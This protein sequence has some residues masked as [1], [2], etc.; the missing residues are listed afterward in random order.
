MVLRPEEVIMVASPLMAIMVL[1]VSLLLRPLAVMVT[2]ITIMVV[3]RHHK[4]EDSRPLRPITVIMVVLW[5]T[6][7]TLSPAMFSPLVGMYSSFLTS[8]IYKIK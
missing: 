7:T 2:A 6:E 4:L 3:S 8:Q 1:Q 5:S